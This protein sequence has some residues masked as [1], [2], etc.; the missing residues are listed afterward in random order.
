LHDEGMTKTTP[1]VSR[2]DFLKIAAAAGALAACSRFNG[3][4]TI[5]STAISPALGQTPTIAPTSGSHPSTNLQ[6]WLATNRILFGPRKSDIEHIGR[7]G[8]DALIEEQLAHEQLDDAALQPRLA[9]FDLLNATPIELAKDKKPAQTLQQLQAMTMTRAVYSSRQLYELMCDFWTNHFN[10]YFRSGPVKYIKHIDDREVIRPHAL[11][12]F[13]DLL[14]ASA[15]SPAMLLYL[16]NDSNVKGKPNE[17][18]ARELMELHTLGVN[19][20]YTQRDVEEVARA[21]TGWSIIGPKQTQN[22][23]GAFVFRPKQHDRDA[24]EILGETFAAGGGKEEGER[25]LDILARHPSAGTFISLKLARRFVADQPPT[26][27]VEKGANAFK[28][29]GGDIKATLGAILHSDEFKQSTGKKVKRP[30]EFVVSALRALNVETDCGAPIQ[31]A[32][33][34]MGQPL[35][36]ME[37]PNGYPDVAGAWQNAG[38]LLARWNFGLALGGNALKGAQTALPRETNIDALSARFFGSELPQSV[39]EKLK[40]FE[41]NPAQLAALMIASPL[42]QT[43]G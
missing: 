19:G 7:I 24:K 1:R 35:F 37:P 29:S 18:Y 40:P 25:V 13:R 20:G 36:L 10:I 15:N 8:V 11:G 22:D 17:N 16:D 33:L 3:E 39:K 41:D 12:K 42:F 38:T 5:V 43:R 26:S 6:S 30:F 34:R 14:G 4:T 27:V 21:F 28:Q 23:A 31:Q 2:R 32:M 9:S